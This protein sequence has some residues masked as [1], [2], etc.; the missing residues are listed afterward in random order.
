MLGSAELNRGVLCKS[1]GCAGPLPADQAQGSWV[2]VLGA[3]GQAAGQQWQGELP[4]LMRLPASV[5]IKV[6]GTL[7]EHAS[8]PRGPFARGVFQAA[9]AA[10]GPA[11]ESWQV[12]QP[13][14]VAVVQDYLIAEGCSRAVVQGEHVAFHSKYYFSQDGIK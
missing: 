7:C 8:G 9:A 4:A 10:S 13:H 14:A 1:A 2:A 6:V 3:V 12:H 11:T 5:S